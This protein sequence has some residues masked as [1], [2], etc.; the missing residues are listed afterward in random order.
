[1]HVT[2]LNSSLRMSSTTQEPI[3]PNSA[4]NAWGEVMDERKIRLACPYCKCMIG[5]K[6]GFVALPKVS[7]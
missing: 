7:R 6:L 1:M 4:G 2:S 3:G 5:A